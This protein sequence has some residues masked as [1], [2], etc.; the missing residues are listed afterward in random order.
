MI[1]FFK[2]GGLLCDNVFEIKVV[3]FV[4]MFFKKGG[5]LYDNV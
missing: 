1:M 2:K 5:L 4:I 3:C